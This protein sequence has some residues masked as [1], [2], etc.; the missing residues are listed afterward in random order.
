MKAEFL[1]PASMAEAAALLAQYGDD[2]KLIAGGT[3]VVLMYKQ[4]LIAPGVFI[5]LGRIK[6]HNYVRFSEDGLHIGALTLLSEAEKSDTLLQANPALAHA[7]GVV[8]NVRI[9]NQATV[10]GN[11]AEADYAS[12]PPAMLVALNASV[13][14][15]R[16]DGGRE[17]PLDEF[18]YGFYTTALE[19]DEI[20]SEVIVPSLSVNARSTYL[21]F[22]SR[23]AEDRP[24]VGVAAAADFD[25]DGKCGR[26][27]V[28][29]GAAVEIPQRLPDIEAQAVGERLSDELIDAIANGYAQSLD[30]L[31]DGR[32]SAWYRREMIKVFV[33][34]ALKEVRNGDR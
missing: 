7:L 18:F 13:K 26:L 29:I 34:R 25:R 6:D 2:A 19:P 27:R 28:V 14:T 23:S 1:E 30:P 24:C 33:R 11:L 31:E 10:G 21:K 16:P 15:I 22:T 4:K 32:G 8:G 20:I 9:R 12:D 17:I 5:S 3:A